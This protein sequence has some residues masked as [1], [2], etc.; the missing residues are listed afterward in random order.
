MMTAPVYQL[1]CICKSSHCRRAVLFYDGEIA[2]KSGNTV[3]VVI[4]PKSATDAIIQA[5]DN[6]SNGSASHREG[7]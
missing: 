5:L 2:I 1:D 3:K 4:I 7:E 6:W